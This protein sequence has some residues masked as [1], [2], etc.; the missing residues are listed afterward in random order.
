MGLFG[1]PCRCMWGAHVHAQ[2]SMQSVREYQFFCGCAGAAARRKG[3]EHFHTTI[4]DANSEKSNLILKECHQ[5]GLGATNIE[6]KARMF[7]VQTLQCCFFRRRSIDAIES[8]YVFSFGRQLKEHTLSS[9]YS[10]LACKNRFRF[11]IT[12]ASRTQSEANALHKEGLQFCRAH[13]VLADMSFR[14]FRDINT[15]VA[16][17]I[18]P[19]RMRCYIVFAEPVL[20]E[21]KAPLD[22]PSQN[23]CSL[24]D[25]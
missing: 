14:S 8:A 13:L 24:A 3:G 15:A 18:Y 7:D 11:L 5:E 12:A 4:K 23:T 19:S 6:K 1:L 10:Y 21:G 16:N 20:Q 9:S 25:N 17:Y 2:M 22:S